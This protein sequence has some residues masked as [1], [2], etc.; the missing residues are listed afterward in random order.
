VPVIVVEPPTHMVEF[1][2]VVPTVGRGLTIIV[3]VAVLVQPVA[4]V[5]PVTVYVVVATGD[6]VIAAVVIP[7]G[8]QLYVLALAAVMV[9]DPPIQMAEELTLVVTF[10]NGF[11]I[12]VRVAVLVQPVAVV[13]P[14]TVY[15]V[16]AAGE[17]VIAAVVI[18]PGCQLYVLALLAVIVV[19]LPWQI[20]D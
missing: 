20:V 8:C 10:G 15:V 9:V 7:P 16:V 12:I 6:T 2:T 17:T 5:V 13:V 11:T 19:E 1:V 14:V 4:V 18:P 3:R